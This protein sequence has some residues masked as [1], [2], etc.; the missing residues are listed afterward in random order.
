MVRAPVES[1]G[2]RTAIK[3]KIEE[4]LAMLG[5]ANLEPAGA[6]VAVGGVEAIHFCVICKI[7]NA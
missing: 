4:L 3:R 2:R 1:H 6:P 7:D 5:L